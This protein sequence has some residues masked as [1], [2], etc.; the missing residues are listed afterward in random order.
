MLTPEEIAQYRETGQVTPRFQLG[1]DIVRAIE[2]KMADHFAARP[3]LG[4]DGSLAYAPPATSQ[5]TDCLIETDRSWLDFAADLDI[6]DMVGQILGDDIIVWASNIFCKEGAGDRATPWHQDGLYW[7][8]RPLE[9]CSVWIAIDHSTPENGCLR[10]IPG[11]HKA[12]R[13]LRH[14]ADNSGKHILWPSD[15]TV[16]A[17]DMP[18][19]EPVDVVLEP[20]MVSLH[21]V[22]TVHGSAP[23][24]SGARRAGLVYRYMPA[25]SHYDRDLAAKL[26]GTYPKGTHMSPERSSIS[27]LHLVRGVD[28]SGLNDVWQPTA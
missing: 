5:F 7:P 10:I 21:D 2:E 17:A 9:A 26:G 20:G 28:V 8:M 11:S 25:S 16:S 22:F 12:G 27:E 18:D 6:L 15:Q 14:G 3:E 13:V 19:V 1:D 4:V 24:T 23:N